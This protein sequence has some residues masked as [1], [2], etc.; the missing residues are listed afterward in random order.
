MVGSALCRRLASESRLLTV[1]REE[2]DLRRQ[3]AV[4]EWFSANRPHAVI[5]AAATVGGIAVNASLPANFI[6]DN[7]AIQTN[8][9]EAARHNKV[10]KL[11]FL[12]SSCVYPVQAS[13][14]VNEDAL[15]TGPLEPTN[16]PYAIAKIAGLKLCQ[17]YRRQYKCDFISATPASL[18][19]EGDTFDSCSS[20][21]LAALILRLYQ[22][23]VAGST[24]ITLWGT[25][26][27]VREFMYVDDF[28]DA[29][30]FLM[31]HYSDDFSINVGSGEEVSIFELATLVAGVIGWSGRFIFD[32][33]RPDGM[34]R[35]CV[36]SRRLNALGWKPRTMLADGIL[37]T[38]E[39]FKDRPVHAICEVS[40]P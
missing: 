4:E 12:S 40:R 37:K 24:E 34:P 22:A 1:G 16:E 9:I 15:L 11:L 39:W 25:G 23:K 18:Y 3:S 28:A 29:A 21:V 10:E 32:L 5:L 31:E 8:V 36:D 7:L 27:P 35:K 14:P 38:Y 13:Q 20:H 26:K 30:A 19:G 2:L 6:Y 17:A 33:S